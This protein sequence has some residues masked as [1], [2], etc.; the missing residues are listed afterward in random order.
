MAKPKKS[1]TAAEAGRKVVAQHKPAERRRPIRDYTNI[2]R[3]PED[4]GIAVAPEPPPP[5]GG[6][7]GGG[8]GGQGDLPPEFADMGLPPEVA[9]RIL[10]IFQSGRD[11]WQQ[12]AIKYLMT[13]DWFAQNYAGFQAGVGTLFRSAFDGGLADYKQY[14]SKLQGIYRQYYGRDLTVQDITSAIASGYDAGRVE[15]Q[16]QGFVNVQANQGDW[17][18]LTGAFGGGQLTEEEKKAYGE[19]LAGI[20]TALGQSIKNKVD[21]AQQRMQGVVQGKVAGSALG[22]QSL[23]AALQRQQRTDI[24]A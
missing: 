22:D 18:Y 15:Q 8:G 21:A 11:D 20:D 1:K 12:Q 10:T 6:G 7:G 4:A 24:H 19:E 23:N 17:Q 5:S 9:A 16:G 14:K 2:G 13:T 3:P